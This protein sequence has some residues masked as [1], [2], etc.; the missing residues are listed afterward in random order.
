MCLFMIFCI[1][2]QEPLDK[3][4][5]KLK[6]EN[7][8]LYSKNTSEVNALLKERDFVWNQLKTRETDLTDK[9]KNKEAEVV[10]QDVKI[11]SLLASMEELQAS[12]KE[13]DDLIADLES[14]MIKLEADSVIKSEE[15]SRLSR[16][17]E[18]VN[19][20]KSDPATP[21]LLGCTAETRRM[22]LGG[23]NSITQNR[24]VTEKKELNSPQVSKEVIV[25]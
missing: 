12:N 8:K 14:K 23:K 13:K 3:E 16:G 15:I 9:L 2:V 11:K 7:E 5:R 6:Q 19:K 20:S 18:S 22:R 25:T 10:Q 17:L 24:N 1:I 21:G 4:L